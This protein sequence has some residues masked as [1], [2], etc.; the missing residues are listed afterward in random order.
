MAPGRSA[1]VGCHCSHPLAGVSPQISVGEPLILTIPVSYTTRALGA[2]H[3]RRRATSAVYP[4]QC[5][6]SAYQLGVWDHLGGGPTAQTDCAETARF[7]R[8][9]AGI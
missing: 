6:N 7:P 3:N 4:D 1:V 5:A 8:N 2:S 9:T